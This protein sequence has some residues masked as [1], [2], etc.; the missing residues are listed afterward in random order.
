MARPLLPALALRIGTMGPE[1]MSCGPVQV[2]GPF[3][4]VTEAEELFGELIAGEGVLLLCEGRVEEFEAVGDHPDGRA[5]G[6]VHGLAG[7]GEAETSMPE[8]F[9]EEVCLDGGEPVVDEGGVVAVVDVVGD[10]DGG[11]GEGVAEH[12]A[13][14]GVAFGAEDGA[15]HVCEDG[16]DAGSEEGGIAGGGVDFLTDGEHEGDFPV[17]EDAAAGAAVGGGFGVIHEEEIH[18][19]DGFEVEGFVDDLVGDGEGSGSR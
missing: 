16:V 3:L 4:G 9:V 7:E 5:F 6:S 1:S 8:V 11:D 17:E 14:V 13:F 18:A 19:L 2:E 10:F 15:G 12:P